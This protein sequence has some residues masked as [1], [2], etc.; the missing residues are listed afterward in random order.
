MKLTR[1]FFLAAGAASA[2]WLA[3]I[4]LFIQLSSYDPYGWAVPGQESVTSRNLWLARR[5]LYVQ[6]GLIAFVCAVVLF[7][8]ALLFKRRT[9]RGTER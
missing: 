4:A 5:S 7:G 2:L 8:L 1:L 9:A 3:S 6:T